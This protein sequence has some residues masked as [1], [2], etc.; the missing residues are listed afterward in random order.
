M[1]RL[2]IAQSEE[3][4][5]SVIEFAFFGEASYQ[6]TD[7]FSVTGGARYFEAPNGGGLYIS[8]YAG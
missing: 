5:E 4:E 2:R 6:I 1:K 3:R 8:L 7:K